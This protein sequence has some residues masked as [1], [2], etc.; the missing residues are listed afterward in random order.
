[1]LSRNKHTNTHTRAHRLCCLP[2][3]L[4]V[5]GSR[6]RLAEAVAAPHCVRLPHVQT[7]G[8][9]LPGLSRGMRPGADLSAFVLSVKT[10]A[11]KDE[12]NG[13]WLSI[14]VANRKLTQ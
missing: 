9:V 14:G 1:M 5:L 7:I 3:L 13:C 6:E 12:R 2:P 10:A 4:P 11:K 8:G